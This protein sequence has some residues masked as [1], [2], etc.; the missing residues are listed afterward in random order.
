MFERC[1]QL[2]GL[3]KCDPQARHCSWPGVW[4]LSSELEVC[5][6]RRGLGGPVF[7]SP[8]I[9]QCSHLLS[10]F[11]G[12]ACT[13]AHKASNRQVPT[14]QSCLKLESFAKRPLG[15]CPARQPGEGPALSLGSCYERPTLENSHVVGNSMV[16]ATPPP[17]PFTETGFVWV[18]PG[19][20][21]GFS[22]LG[23]Q[24]RSAASAQGHSGD[25]EGL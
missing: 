24:A 1:L 10:P 6:G 7:P 11:S 20:E 17:S 15:H 18:Y 25:C 5:I 22:L 9:L 12:Q 14:N 23:T 2:S 19:N 3:L 21:Q 8:K 4:V 16:F 13:S